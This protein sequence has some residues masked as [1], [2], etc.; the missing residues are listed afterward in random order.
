MREWYIMEGQLQNGPFS[1]DELR[2]RFEKG[3]L[4]QNT[5]V[6][7]EGLESWVEA[8]QIENLVSEQLLSSVVHP[9][10]P[11]PPPIP[12][13]AKPMEEDPMMRMMLPVGRSGWAIAAGYLGLFALVLFPGP[14]ALLISIVAIIDIQRSKKTPTPKRGMGRALFGLITGLLASVFLLILAVAG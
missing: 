3:Q 10:P 8:H 2:T 5:L 14:L 6:W 4:P 13:A 12:G 1:E 9:A 7:A 11:P